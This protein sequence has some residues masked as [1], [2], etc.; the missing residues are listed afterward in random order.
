MSMVR[1]KALP[2]LLMPS[3]L[4]LPPVVCCR[5]TIEPGWQIASSGEGASVVD[6]G[7]QSRRGHWPDTRYRLVFASAFARL[8]LNLYPRSY[9]SASL[10]VIT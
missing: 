8:P 1:I 2:R 6:G 10:C 7:T 9:L 5:G 4:G 3:S